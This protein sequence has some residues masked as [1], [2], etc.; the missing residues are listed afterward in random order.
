[1][2]AKPP[3]RRVFMQQRHAQASFS[4]NQWSEETG[5]VNSAVVPD[6][7]ARLRAAVTGPLATRGIWT[8]CS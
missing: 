2:R 8:R 4:S 6:V 1:M 5:Q 7:R 3:H